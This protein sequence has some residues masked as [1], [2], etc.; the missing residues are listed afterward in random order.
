MIRAMIDGVSSA[1]FPGVPSPGD[2]LTVDGARCVVKQ[3][4]WSVLSRDPDG[5][6]PLPRARLI[7]HTE[8]EHQ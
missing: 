8:Q 3:V 5:D 7:I 6:D 1:M 2:R 4:E